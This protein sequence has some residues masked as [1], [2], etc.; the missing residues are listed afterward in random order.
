MKDVRYK[1]L[2]I[3]LV[4]YTLFILI[5]SFIGIGNQTQSHEFEFKKE[6]IESHAVVPKSETKSSEGMKFEFNKGTDPTPVP[7]FPPVVIVEKR[8]NSK[9]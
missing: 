4:S 3:T 8:L 9:S 5:F 7:H 6:K 1:I 2:L